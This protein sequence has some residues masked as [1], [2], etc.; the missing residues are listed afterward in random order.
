MIL[1]RKMTFLEKE[2]E[3]SRFCSETFF[4]EEECFKSL[5]T[6]F[7]KSQDLEPE[8]NQIATEEFWNLLME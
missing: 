3:K 7:E 6:Y 4:T 1:K 8:F 2:D 5:I